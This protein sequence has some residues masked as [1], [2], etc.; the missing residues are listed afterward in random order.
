MSYTGLSPERREPTHTLTISVPL[1]LGVNPAAQEWDI[2]E[3]FREALRW[4]L[5]VTRL[6]TLGLLCGEITV[7]VESGGA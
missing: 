3:A 1:D 6:G 4:I 2:Q 5:P 7:D